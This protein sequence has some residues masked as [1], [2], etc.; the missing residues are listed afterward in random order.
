M[1][2][3]G[4]Y[5]LLIAVVLLTL[6]VSL[7]L[8]ACGSD[9]ATPLA[10]VFTGGGEGDFGIS[11]AVTSGGGS[12]S[13]A[14]WEIPLDASCSEGIISGSATLRDEVTFSPPLPI[15]DGRFEIQWAG[16]GGG[17]KGRFTGDG[18]Q[19]TGNWKS[20]DCSGSWDATLE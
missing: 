15:E 8:V 20:G 14:S 9:G 16:G 13:E 5:F 12:M 19:A 6:V 17:I 1:R 10:G 7:G 11:F 4:R 18:T 2:L 3:L